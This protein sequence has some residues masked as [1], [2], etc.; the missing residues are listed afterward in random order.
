MLVPALEQP[1]EVPG[2]R[3]CVVHTREQAMLEGR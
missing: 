1:G 2:L 3:Q